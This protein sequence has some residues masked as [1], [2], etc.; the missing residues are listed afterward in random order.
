MLS[1]EILEKVLVRE[2]V[3]EVPMEYKSTMIHAISEAIE[4]VEREHGIWN[5]TTA[6]Y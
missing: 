5:A 3:S 2:D 1:D 6:I 4:E